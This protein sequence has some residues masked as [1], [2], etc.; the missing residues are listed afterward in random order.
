MFL[1]RNSVQQEVH[2]N[3]Y[4][5]L[6]VCIMQLTGKLLDQFNLYVTITWLTMREKEFETF[7]DLSQN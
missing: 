7:D 2:G 5:V 1:S 4:E 3:C 6:P